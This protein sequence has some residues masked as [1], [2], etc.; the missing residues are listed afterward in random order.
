MADKHMHL[1]FRAHV[2]ETLAVSGCHT[3]WRE[4]RD[5]GL[6]PGAWQRP[7]IM[8]SAPLSLQVGG[9]DPRRRL[10]PRRPRRPSRCRQTAVTCRR[11]AAFM[12][13]W[14]PHAG[15]MGGSDA[16][17]HILLRD[18]RTHSSTVQSL[19]KCCTISSDRASFICR[20]GCCPTP[21]ASSATC[22]TTRAAA[23]TSPRWR[24]PARARRQRR[25][26]SRQ[27]RRSAVRSAMC[28]DACGPRARQASSYLIDSMTIKRSNRSVMT[29]ERAG[30]E[31]VPGCCASTSQPVMAHLPG[32]QPT[33]VLPPICRKPVGCQ[34]V[35]SPG[36]SS[37][38]D[39]STSRTHQPNSQPQPE[40]GAD[41]GG[42][43]GAGAHHAGRD[44]H[45]VRHRRRRRPAERLRERVHGAV[46]AEPGVAV[47][48]A[49]QAPAASASAA[50]RA[51]AQ[52]HR[53]T[54]DVRAKCPPCREFHDLA[55]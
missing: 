12:L 46:G 19:L 13:Y 32:L 6:S 53:R 20:V 7:L 42:G 5:T 50:A 16:D 55:S 40:P 2:F 22:S 31:T 14:S 3:S 39:R 15:T 41:S 1:E 11:V 21:P 38:T 35:A 34:P 24:A 9:R 51:D 30:C 45:R 17:G 29:F 10:S 4:C 25:R 43:R 52:P 49:V 37:S 47:T 8:T 23:S 26:P 28:P 33:C 44:R 18:G 54:G 27:T 48:V 36:H